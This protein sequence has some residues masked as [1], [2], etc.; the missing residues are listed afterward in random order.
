MDKESAQPVSAVSKAL[1]MLKRIR[2]LDGSALISGGVFLHEDC[3]RGTDLK[4]FL[5][6][7][8][9]MF[10]QYGTMNEMAKE[11]LLGFEEGEI[12]FIF[13][14]PVI[15][16]LFFHREEELHSIE[17]GGKQFL[18]QFSAILGVRDRPAFKPAIGGKEWSDA[19]F[20]SA[21]A[22]PPGARVV[23]P[24][25]GVSKVNDKLSLKVPKSTAKVSEKSEK[26][27]KPG[28]VSMIVPA[29]E[30]EVKPVEPEQI[31]P[32]TRIAEPEQKRD[33]RRINQQQGNDPGGPARQHSVDPDYQWRC[34]VG[35]V[36]QPG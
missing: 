4:M 24:K 32:I 10:D 21:L 28:A 18:N 12:L 11:I 30:P 19:R 13:R 1:N 33:G 9:Q 25:N 27:P 35:G 15:L 34:R 22:A 23:R 31:R 16:C 29:P 3:P 2:R 7:T 6:S 26:E 5:Q 17:A 20:H 14:Y 8:I 36:S